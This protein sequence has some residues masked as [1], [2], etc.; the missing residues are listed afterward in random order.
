MR[1]FLRFPFTPAPY[2]GWVHALLAAL[3]AAAAAAA[4]LMSMLWWSGPVPVF[5]AA[6]WA[7]SGLLGLPTPSRRVSV[8][9]AN[10]LLAARLPKPMLPR[11]FAAAAWMLAW[12]LAG[13]AMALVSGLALVTLTLPA[14]W[15]GGGGTVV[16]GT[17]LTVPA[18]V[19]GA[20]TLAAAGGAVLAGLGACAG[21]AALMR[22]LARLLL[23]PGLA[24]RLAAAEAEADRAAARNRLARDLHDSIGH[25]LTASTIQA[26]VAK[27]A[28]ES[29]P[30][31]ARSAMAAIEDGSRAALE[32]LDRT[33][34]V[35]RGEPAPTRPE[36]DLSDL[37]ALR[38]RIDRTGAELAV[39]TDG[40]TAAVASPVS[41]EAYRIVQEGVT[42]ALKHA[43]GASIRVRL[44]V[45]DAHLTVEV[46]NRITRPQAHPA[47]G[48]GLTG[49]AERA[50][51][52][53]GT[54]AA[55]P[56]GEDWTLRAELPL[57]APARR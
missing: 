6:V 30:E 11:R 52:L 54:A 44:A 25:T 56:D 28:M 36:P 40:D 19:A 31:G 5:A 3:P 41:R 15:A 37:A 48:R 1:Q 29:D 21:Y 17:E 50:R 16:F 42:N 2:R 8:R 20:W 57:Q 45:A 10:G 35:L 13:G 55:G 47:P 26:A 32:D 51:L 53:G 23:G 38:D 4:V 46:A 18:G 43:P 39:E 22:R 14:V 24:E 7:A 49:T 12:T 33:L 9:L 27:Q 34:G